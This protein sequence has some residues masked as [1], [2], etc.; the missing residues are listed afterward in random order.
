M[1]RT[2]KEL[3]ATFE[4]PHLRDA[5]VWFRRRGAFFDGV[6]YQFPE[7]L[8]DLTP[9]PRGDILTF[10]RERVIS[11]VKAVPR[12]RGIKPAAHVA[13]PPV[14]TRL[15]DLPKALYGRNVLFT[16]DG[17]EPLEVP[18]EGGPP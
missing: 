13:Y 12:Q 2:S 15:D 4:L 1:T 10:Y 7:A 16:P 9:A 17:I 6:D 3:I 5:F 18:T 14:L 8:D 11:K